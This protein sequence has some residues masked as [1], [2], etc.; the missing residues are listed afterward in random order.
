MREAGLSVRTGPSDFSSPG[1]A[2][3]FV[4]ESDMTRLSFSGL[5]LSEVEKAVKQ[6]NK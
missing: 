4:D 2:R 1:T 6:I 5:L 3:M